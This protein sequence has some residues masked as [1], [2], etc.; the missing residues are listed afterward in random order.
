MVK[1]IL[2]YISV[3]LFFTS[4]NS[5]KPLS[6]TANRQASSTSNTATP[7][8]TETGKKDIKFI[9]DIS[10]SASKQ[11]S[12]STQKN[13]KAFVVKSSEAPAEVNKEIVSTSSKLEAANALQIKYSILLNT[14]VE[15]LNNPELY[16]KIDEWYG[17]RYRFGGTTKQGIDCS[18]F[19]QVLFSSI[20]G[21]VLPRTARD[22]YKLSTRISRTEM[23][24]GDLLF[25][26]TRG[27]VSHVGY[28]LQNNKFVHASTNGVTISDIFD[29]YYLQ[30]F[31]GVGR[32][33]TEK[34]VKK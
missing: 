25:F 16:K 21:F 4:C 6:F 14:E 19:V 32:I 34:L 33:D 18:A 29:P 27:G 23:R 9:E 28:Y 30:R 1:Q 12:E 26:N 8:N 24:E 17:T 2:S 31:I 7:K 5:L 13:E 3:I 10:A 11:P 15:N 22:Q 20:Y